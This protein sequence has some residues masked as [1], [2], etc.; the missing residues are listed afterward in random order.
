MNKYKITVM[1]PLGSFTM[2]TLGE[3]GGEIKNKIDKALSDGE[4]QQKVTQKRL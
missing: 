1:N 2:D 3:S 4:E